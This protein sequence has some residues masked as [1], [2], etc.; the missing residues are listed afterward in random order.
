[1]CSSQRQRRQRGPAT[2]VE[3]GREDW[4]RHWVSRVG[5][6]KRRS[7]RQE[8]MNNYHSSTQADWLERSP[9]MTPAEPESPGI[10]Y[11]ST[12]GAGVQSARMQFEMEISPWMLLPPRSGVNSTFHVKCFMSYMKKSYWCWGLCCCY[13]WNMHKFILTYFI[14]K[15]QQEGGPLQ[16]I[17]L[18]ISVKQLLRLFSPPARVHR[19][20]ILL[21]CTECF[22][23]LVPFLL[24]YCPQT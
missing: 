23:I 6:C 21:F 13:L 10:K 7:K 24:F 22:C 16:G 1:M 15:M 11:W 18:T 8:P 4:I 3:R 2:A 17:S 20:P 14:P 9:D 19:Y 12:N 5:L